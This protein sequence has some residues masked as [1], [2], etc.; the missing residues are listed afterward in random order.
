M[1]R[2]SQAGSR[3][4]SRIL[5]DCSCSSGPCVPSLLTVVTLSVVLSVLT[6]RTD[7]EWRH[8]S[9]CLCRETAGQ[10]SAA[11]L[12]HNKANV[13]GS[14]GDHSIAAQGNKLHNR[15]NQTRWVEI[16][17]NNSLS[18]LSNIWASFTFQSPNIDLA[19]SCQGKTQPALL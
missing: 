13:R 8:F 3:L 10:F 6:T 16:H 11:K 2:C 1:V 15:I 19:L 12:P 4:M 18:Q 9:L 5:R 7:V 14:G 17:K